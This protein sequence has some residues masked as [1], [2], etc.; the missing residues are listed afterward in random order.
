MTLSRYDHRD[1][2][3]IAEACAILRAAGRVD[4]PWE[5]PITPYRHR[6]LVRHGLEGEPATAYLL[7]TGDGPAVGVAELFVSHWDNPSVGWARLIVDPR[8]RHRGH[9]RTG[10][11]DLL[12]EARRHHL[13]HLTLEAYDTPAAQRL[14]TGAGFREVY[15]ETTRLLELDRIAPATLTDLTAEAVPYAGDYE[16]LRLAGATPEPLL[17]PLA[18]LTGVINDAPTDD[19]VWEPEVF[20]VQ[21]I[22]EAETAQL[23]GGWRPYRVIARRRDSGELAGHTKVLVDAEDPTAAIQ[24]DTAVAGAHRGHRLGLVL[25]TEMMRWL[26]ADEP[27]VH[28]LVTSN[29]SSNG[30]MIAVNERLGYRPV[31]DLVYF[32]GTV[33]L[34]GADDLGRAGDPEP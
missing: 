27:G 12:A 17:A 30:P 21:R 8:H 16:L 10:L 28:Q 22:R 11:R 13:T 9:G 4:A 24:L 7:R 32:Q 34:Q 6:M 15:R 23:A 18:E 1:D 14:G 20:P 33:D 5:H 25:K 31:A 19:L 3:A 2:D 29:A 26:L